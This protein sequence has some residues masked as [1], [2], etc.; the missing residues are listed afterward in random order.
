MAYFTYKKHQI[1]YKDYGK[2]TPVVFLHG[3]TASSK[4]FVPILHHFEQHFRIIIIDFLGHGY[5]DRLSTF[6]ADLWFD[7]A[8]QVITLLETLK[9]RQAHLVGSSGGALVAINIAL[10]RPDLVGKIVADSFEGES[11]V[12]A[13]TENL[14]AERQAS[15]ENMQA[16]RFYKMMHGDDWESVVDNDT[17]AIVAHAERMKAFFHHPI[18]TLKNDILMIGTQQDRCVSTGVHYLAHTYGEILQ[19]IGHGAF[20]IFATGDHPALISNSDSFCKI[21][22]AFLL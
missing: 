5:S 13:F 2:G 15:K 3:N 6:P 1:H 4:M 7:E 12:D 10:E 22:K 18:D 8:M 21:V 19:R 16:K 11:A 14:V 9:I 17:A 20:Y